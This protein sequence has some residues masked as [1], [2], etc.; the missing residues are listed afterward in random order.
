MLVPKMMEMPGDLLFRDLAIRRG[1]REKLAANVSLGGGALRGVN[2]CGVRA[3]DSVVQSRDALDSKY[4]RAGASEDEEN[5]FGPENLA[6]F[7][8]D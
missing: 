1:N 7:F 3:N 4:V 2:V 6:E 5:F 8:G